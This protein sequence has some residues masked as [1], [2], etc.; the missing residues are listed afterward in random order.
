MSKITKEDV[1]DAEYIKFVEKNYAIIKDN[2][3]KVSEIFW[4]GV[5]I[6]GGVISLIYL[7]AIALIK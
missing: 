1:F 7:T 6:G 2:S 3:S 4:R 5:L